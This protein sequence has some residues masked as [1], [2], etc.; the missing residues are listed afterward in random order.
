[1]TCGSKGGG[2]V[3]FLTKIPMEEPHKASHV[4]VTVTDPTQI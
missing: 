1:M 2:A 3:L 4:P